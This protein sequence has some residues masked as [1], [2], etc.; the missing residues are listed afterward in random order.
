M[1][2]EEKVGVNQVKGCGLWERG[3]AKAPKI[4]EKAN[5]AGASLVCPSGE[6]ADGPHRGEHIYYVSHRVIIT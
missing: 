6:G 3:A 4:L 1:S 5:V 2:L